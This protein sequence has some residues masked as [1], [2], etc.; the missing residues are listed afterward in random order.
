MVRP[1][2]E[3]AG[4][5]KQELAAARA[6]SEVLGIYDKMED[7]R[8]EGKTLAEAAEILKLPTRV[9]EAVDRSGRNPQG[10]PVSIPE[11][12]RLLRRRA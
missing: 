10:V 1:L 2:E 4:E 12:Q 5:L 9:I 11:Q 7:A 3:V 6:K 8:S